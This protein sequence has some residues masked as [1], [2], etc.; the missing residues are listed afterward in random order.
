MD[1]VQLKKL[2]LALP[3]TKITVG[4]GSSECAAVAA[5]DL[6]DLKGYQE[7]ILASGKVVADVKV[8]VR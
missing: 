6:R 1:P 2:R 3:H 5:F 4:Y 8:K 7:N